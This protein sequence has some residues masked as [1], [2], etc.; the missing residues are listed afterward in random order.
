M[1][2]RGRLRRRARKGNRDVVAFPPW[3]DRMLFGIT[4]VER[5]LALGFGS[6]SPAGGSV[7]AI[8]MR[9]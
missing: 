9:P 3:Q 7:L 4:E 1:H 8:A 6:A 2:R 5:Q